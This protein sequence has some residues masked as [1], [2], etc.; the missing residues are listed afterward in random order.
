MLVLIKME[1]A[2]CLRGS[3]ALRSHYT[4]VRERL[5]GDTYLQ[6]VIVI[7]VAIGVHVVVNVFSKSN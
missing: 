2:C 7:Y 4:E 1:F 6:F 3:S 5:T